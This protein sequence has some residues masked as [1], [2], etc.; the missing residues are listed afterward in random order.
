MKRVLRPATRP[1]R[2]T[3]P[4]AVLM[5]ALCAGYL[6]WALTRAAVTGLHVSPIVAVA[7]FGAVELAV[8]VVA[9]LRWNLQARVS[10]SVTRLAYALHAMP[11]RTFLYC[12]PAM[13]LL[14]GSDRVSEP[15]GPILMIF[16]VVA[17]VLA[18]AV[19]LRRTR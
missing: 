5:V 1:A 8:V 6:S 3:R 14:L 11:V 10:E 12:V 2:V 17:F 18:S 15:T 9:L 4:A 13:A 19:L 16:A 7:G